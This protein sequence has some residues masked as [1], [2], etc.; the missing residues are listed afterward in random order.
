M[1][2]VIIKPMWLSHI[3]KQQKVN[4]G[5]FPLS[6]SPGNIWMTPPLIL[7]ELKPVTEISWCEI[8]RPDQ[9]SCAIPSCVDI[10]GTRAQQEY[11]AMHLSRVLCLT[12]LA[13]S[14]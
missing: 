11:N 8:S 13:V 7:Q 14:C 4:I 5:D 2:F 12:E 10:T 6:L 9:L 1:F 3:K